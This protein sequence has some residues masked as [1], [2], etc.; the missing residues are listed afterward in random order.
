MTASKAKP[1]LPGA[2]ESEF[3]LALEEV[4]EGQS[5]R[6]V[7]VDSVAA[8]AG[9]DPDAGLKLALRLAEAK[10]T[11]TVNWI[12]L[13]DNDPDVIDQRG[14]HVALSR[15]ARDWCRAERHQLVTSRELR[16]WGLGH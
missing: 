14:G 16:A 8:H 1:F 7:S 9:L 10:I 12:T 6:H 15:S 3:L 2:P 5:G 4:A 13:Q 11:A